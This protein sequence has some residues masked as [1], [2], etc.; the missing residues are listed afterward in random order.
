VGLTGAGFSAYKH[1]AAGWELPCV[2]MQ[3]WSRGL[4][5]SNRGE[6]YRGTY[7]FVLDEANLK[8][9]KH[10]SHLNR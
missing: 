2:C 4:H 10:S 1:S 5:S 6:L 8:L 9:L 3:A 7:I